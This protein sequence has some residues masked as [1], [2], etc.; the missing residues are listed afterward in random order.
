MKHIGEIGQQDLWWADPEL[1]ELLKSDPLAAVRSLGLNPPEGAPVQ[2][3]VE[4]AKVF[5]VIWQDGRIIAKR[6]FAISPDDEG[7]LFGRGIWESTRTFSG[8]PWLWEAHLGR[9]DHTARVLNLL[10]DPSRLPNAE[11][12]SRYVRSLTGMDVIIRLNASAGGAGR[13]GSVWMSA[14][15][16]PAPIESIR[17]QTCK[18]PVPKEQPYLVWKTFQYATR[19]RVGRPT[20]PGFDSTLLVDDDGR[21]LEAAHANLFVRTDDGWATPTLDGG[22]LPGTVRRH[23]LKSSPIPIAER[24]ILEAELRDVHEVFLTN[25]NVGIVPVTR[26]D[27]IDYPIGDET[28]TLAEWIVPEPRFAPKRLTV[29]IS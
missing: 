23:L 29:A 15:L 1:R 3:L 8:R 25:S 5:S 17:L 11:T 10:V 22:A 28:R 27:D 7:L 2:A 13:P 24:E 20:A 21:L 9:L 4:A 18:S 6:D 26:I 12:V 14:S 16:P 19:L